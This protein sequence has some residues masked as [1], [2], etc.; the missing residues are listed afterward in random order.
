MEESV[1]GQKMY[2]SIFVSRNTNTNLKLNKDFKVHFVY[3]RLS[4]AMSKL[5]ALEMS[6]NDALST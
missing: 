4:E 6:R 1:T 5:D 3:F 2:I